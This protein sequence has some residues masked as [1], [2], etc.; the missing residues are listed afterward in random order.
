LQHFLSSSP[1]S[2]GRFLAVYRSLVGQPSPGQLR[3]WVVQ[4]LVFPKSGRHSVGALRQFARPL[5]RKINCQVAVAVSELRADGFFPLAL[6]LYLPGVWLREHQDRAERLVPAE[7]REHLSK[8]DLAVRL[9]DELLAEGRT[10]TLLTADEG[11]LSTGDFL[12]AVV[13]RGI[14]VLRPEDALAPSDAGRNGWH[15]EGEASVSAWDLV[16][17][18]HSAPG[19]DWLRQHLGLD[20]F[21]GRSWLGWHHHAALVLAAYGFL[22]SELLGS[23]L[24]PFP[25]AHAPA[26][27]T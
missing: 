16:K 5:G 14:Q 15:A 9:L 7:H 24:P 19:F 2:V 23:G 25:L 13:G 6:R 27:A 3:L 21:E 18:A 26:A 1:W 4:D 22:A 17:R 10:T 12:D 11:F 8:C 20:H